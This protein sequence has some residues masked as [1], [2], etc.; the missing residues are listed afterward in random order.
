MRHLILWDGEQNQVCS[1]MASAGVRN[2]AM[3]PEYAL[4]VTGEKNS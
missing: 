1:Y 4:Y 3:W 2:E